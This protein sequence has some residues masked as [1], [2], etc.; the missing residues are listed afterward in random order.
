[1]APLDEVLGR[2]SP[3]QVALRKWS[4]LQMAALG[5]V[6]CASPDTRLEEH[7]P[8]ALPAAATVSE[9]AVFWAMQRKNWTL[10]TRGIIKCCSGECRP[11]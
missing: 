2:G 3:R 6:T 9:A 7:P 1:M 5:D 4:A 8:I 11:A 10:K